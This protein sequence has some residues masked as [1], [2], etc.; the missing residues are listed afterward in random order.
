MDLE[1]VSVADAASMLKYTVPMMLRICARAACSH[2][3]FI[4][5]RSEEKG[6]DDMKYF[7]ERNSLTRYYE[8][9]P[10]NDPLI[11]K[12]IDDWFSY[13]ETLD[14]LCGVDLDYE[15]SAAD[16]LMY[17]DDISVSFAP[18]RNFQLVRTKEVE[19]KADSPNDLWVKMIS[20]YKAAKILGYPLTLMLRICARALD[21]GRPFVVIRDNAN[22]GRYWIEEQSV[23]RYFKTEPHDDKLLDAI[24][25]CDNWFE[26]TSWAFEQ[27]D[28][29]D[30]LCGTQIDKDF[31]IE[32][33]SL[34]A[35]EIA[36]GKAEADY[37]IEFNDEPIAFDLLYHEVPMS[38]EEYKET[39]GDDYM[40]EGD[41]D[42]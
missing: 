24:E 22:G 11:D 36:S 20:P 35:D 3:P 9:R 19:W 26:N 8:T 23:L 27:N 14:L 32:D 6:E 4:V 31:S 30:I 12:E 33:L 37:D 5:I 29:L 25:P 16:I 1:F 13:D 18:D 39:Y 17:E 15:F 40:D 7:V 41:I 28:F 10:E 21:S 34:Y 38:R 2:R 42:R